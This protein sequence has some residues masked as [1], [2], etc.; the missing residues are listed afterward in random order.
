MLVPCK[1][2][3]SIS[4]DIEDTQGHADLLHDS[5]WTSVEF[6]SDRGTL[7]KETLIVQQRE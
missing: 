1:S 3:T 2:S 7:W 5:A 4:Q 6:Q